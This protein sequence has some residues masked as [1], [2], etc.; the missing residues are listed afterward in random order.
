M[1]YPHV[2]D[3]VIEYEKVDPSVRMVQRL[4]CRRVYEETGDHL[5]V[6]SAFRVNDPGQHGA[7]AALDIG[8][9]NFFEN[10]LLSRE[11][12]AEFLHEILSELRTIFE[13]ADVVVLLKAD[14]GANHIHLQQGWRNIAGGAS[15][16]NHNNLICNSA[17]KKILTKTP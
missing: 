3:N 12:A 13:E 8:L 5:P 6:T 4:I 14:E 11:S 1:S 10:C 15:A 9:L 7:H 16:W 17:T 2:Y